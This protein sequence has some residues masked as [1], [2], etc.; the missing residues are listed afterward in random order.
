MSAWTE[1]SPKVHNNS[2]SVLSISEV[3]LVQWV[4]KVRTLDTITGVAH[5]V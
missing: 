3:A 5:L 2:M 4:F 1:M